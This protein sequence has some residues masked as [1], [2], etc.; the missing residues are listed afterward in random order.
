MASRFPYHLTKQLLLDY[1]NNAHEGQFDFALNGVV[2]L[3]IQRGAYQSA[4][5]H[6]Y[7]GNDA[8]MLLHAA[9]RNDVTELVRQLFWKLLTEGIL[10]FGRDENN[11]N[12][13]WYRL[14]ALGVEVDSNSSPQPYDPDG[15]I[16][17]FR[18][19]VVGSDPVVLDYQEE[20]V[21][22]FNHQ[23]PKG[24]AVL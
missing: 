4:T 6:S 15:F 5:G 23:C 11:P 18:R 1:L 16:R 20:A 9:D 2:N 8:R 12:W 14:T 17:E 7:D 21:R 19:V 3:A 10:V 13:P 22:C 24:A